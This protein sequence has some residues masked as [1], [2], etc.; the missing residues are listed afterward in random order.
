MDSGDFDRVTRR[1]GAQATRR[2]ALAALLGGALLL[3]DNAPSDA[4]DR[5]QRR[6]RRKRNQ[7]QKNKKQSALFK[8]GI[9][10]ILDNSQG[11]H[12]IT[13]ESGEVGHQAR[14]CEGR[15]LFHIPPGETRLFDTDADGAYAWI[16][17]KLWIEFFNPFVGKPWVQAAEGGMASGT[18]RCCKPNGEIELPEYDLAEGE[19]LAFAVGGYA[20]DVVRHDDKPDFKFFTITLPADL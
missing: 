2:A 14:C 13:V 12:T 8:R 3:G 17:D 19:D 5:A 1:V 9:S 10:Y 11:T 20:F 7:R 4:T 15:A 18:P 6:K 16:S